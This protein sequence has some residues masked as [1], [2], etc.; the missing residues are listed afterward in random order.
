MVQS[1][2][3]KKPD[4]PDLEP[5]EVLLKL[6]E[7]E[8]PD[9]SE[10]QQRMVGLLEGFAR[11][12]KPGA[13]VAINI[14]QRLGDPDPTYESDLRIG[15]LVLGANVARGSY[16]DEISRPVVEQIITNL[17]QDPGFIDAF[18]PQADA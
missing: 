12:K 1:G 13:A 3:P 2:P 5:V 6:A 16:G 8:T 10:R 9:L 14:L 18:A 17:G 7:G 15:M 4:T 11:D